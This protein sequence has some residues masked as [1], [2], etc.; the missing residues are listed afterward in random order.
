M[1]KKQEK[2]LNF[3]QRIYL[4]LCEDQAFVL[5]NPPPVINATSI[6]RNYRFGQ[7]II[8]RYPS[9]AGNKKIYKI[10]GLIFIIPFVLVMLGLVVV[11]VFRLN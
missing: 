9:L 3:F 8:K 6:D 11:L 7:Y 2:K 4:R 1:D 10:I 5:D